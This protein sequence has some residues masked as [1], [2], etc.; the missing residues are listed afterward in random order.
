M[1]SSSL[2]R[3]LVALALIGSLVGCAL[4]LAPSE[5]GSDNWERE[6]GAPLSSAQIGKPAKANPAADT[7]T[8]QAAKR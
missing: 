5:P 6:L 2:T 1:K 3:P 8:Q 7:E 4:P